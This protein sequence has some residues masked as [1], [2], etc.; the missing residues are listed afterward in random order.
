LCVIGFLADR[1]RGLGF[2]FAAVKRPLRLNHGT[3]NDV[4]EFRLHAPI[5]Q[6]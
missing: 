1:C 2:G 5:S 6:S 3:G 4:A